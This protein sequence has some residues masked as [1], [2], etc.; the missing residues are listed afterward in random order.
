MASRFS[1]ISQ[2]GLIKLEYIGSNLA[3]SNRKDHPFR[4]MQAMPK[5]KSPIVLKWGAQ[6]AHPLS[7]TKP[8]KQGYPNCTYAGQWCKKLWTPKVLPQ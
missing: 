6:P 1:A 3:T 8:T 7:T 5:S 2:A 4:E